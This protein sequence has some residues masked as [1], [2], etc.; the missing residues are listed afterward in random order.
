MLRSFFALVETQLL[1]K[2]LEPRGNLRPAVKKRRSA[3]PFAETEENR[4]PHDRHPAGNKKG[5]PHPGK[6]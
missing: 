1:A 3:V 6:A 5:L 2:T 4:P